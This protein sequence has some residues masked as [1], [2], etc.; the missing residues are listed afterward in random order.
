[1]LKQLPPEVV[2]AILQHTDLATAISVEHFLQRLPSPSSND[3]IQLARLWSR[4]TLSDFPASAHLSTNLLVLP[5]SSIDGPATLLLPAWVAVFRP[6]AITHALVDAAAEAGHADLIRL[7]HDLGCD[8]FSTRT[9]DAAAG[10]GH[11]DLV[12]FLHAHRA[13]GCTVDAANGAAGAGAFDVLTFLHAN[14]T[15]GCTE[16]AMELAAKAGAL[17]V[18]T[19]LH[20]H[21][22]GEASEA[23]VSAAATSGHVETLRYL[24]ETMAAPLG[25]AMALAAENGHLDAVAYCFGC[26]VDP[27]DAG[28]DLHA[29]TV[30]QV[31]EEGFVDV[32][33]FLHD[34]FPGAP[35][36]SS[37]AFDRAATKGQVKVLEFVLERFGGGGCTE[38]GFAGAAKNG[39]L[40]TVKMLHE[41]FRLRIDRKAVNAAAE[42]GHVDILVYL[43]ERTVPDYLNFQTLELAVRNG[44]FAVLQFLF[45]RNVRFTSQPLFLSFS[46]YGSADGYLECIRFLVDAGVHFVE[47]T[48]KS[49]LIVA[50][51]QD[52]VDMVRYFL[53]RLSDPIGTHLT[54]MA[55]EAGSLAVLDFLHAHHPSDLCTEAAMDNAANL[56]VLKFLHE[57]RRAPFTSAAMDAAAQT[58]DLDMVAYLHGLGAPF[59]S[60][61][62]EQAAA[63]GHLAVLKFLIS[64]RREPIPST[65]IAAA[66]TLDVVRLLVERTDSAHLDAWV[67]RCTVAGAEVVAYLVT[68]PQRPLADGLVPLHIHAAEGR[69]DAVRWLVERRLARPESFAE[70]IMGAAY[71]RHRRL[72]R[73]F[74]EELGVHYPEVAEYLEM[75]AVE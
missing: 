43:A 51:R 27:D 56:R 39:H 30:R 72:V 38:E 49:A 25:K 61:A 14:R 55:A 58:G 8:R 62:L 13:E 3:P 24:H 26:I 44:R 75:I 15:E 40:E 11:L 59:T 19:F 53:E 47:P 66:A 37:D 45:D 74:R 46:G 52:S 35:G 70:A 73:Y 54:D 20:E 32:L 17:D 33:T 31:C 10:G 23:A 7:L 28:E 9:L 67:R 63:R 34:R 48:L 50:T 68:A 22:W 4:L 16:E 18:V 57:R 29:S 69:I 6:D 41:T 64:R 71:G 5:P 36:W 2:T 42:E 12:K 65:A 21:G 1:M 60:A